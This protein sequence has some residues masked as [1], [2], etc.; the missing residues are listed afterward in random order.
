MARLPIEQRARIG[1]YALSEA[2]R[3]CTADEAPAALRA[4]LE[5][6]LG[7]AHAAGVDM[8]PILEELEKKHRRH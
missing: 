2:L 1:V 7:L 6:L 3:P 8:R 5:Y 4:V